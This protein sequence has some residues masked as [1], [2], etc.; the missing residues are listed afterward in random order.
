MFEDTVHT[1]VKN[2]QPDIVGYGDVHNAFIQHIQ[3]KTL[4]NTGSVGNPLDVTQA[5]YVILEGQYGSEKSSSFSIQFVRVPYDIEFAIQLARLAKMP[6]LEPYI[7]ELT[8][9]RYRGIK[10]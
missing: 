6:D 8:T 4:F 10:K 9:A 5:S 3:G 7:I 2:K 1:D